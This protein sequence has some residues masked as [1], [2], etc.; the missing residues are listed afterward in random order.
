MLQV[1]ARVGQRTIFSSCHAPLKYPPKALNGFL[2][3]FLSLLTTFAVF[4]VLAA[5]FSS[6]FF[7][8]FGVSSV[9]FMRRTVVF[10]ESEL[11]FC[12]IISPKLKSLFQQTVKPSVHQAAKNSKSLPFSAKIERVMLTLVLIELYM[13]AV[14]ALGFSAIKLRRSVKKYRFRSGAAKAR[15][16][17]L[18]A[19]SVCLPARNETNSMTECLEAVLASDYPKMEVIVLDDNSSD[20]TSHL[21]RAFAHAGV[22]F[23]AGDMP[24]GGWVGRNFALQTLLDEASGK[25][26]LFMDVD[27]R[28]APH[29]ISDIVAYALSHEAKMVS[30]VPQRFDTFRASAKFSTLRYFWEMVL[31][32]PSRPGSSTAV[33][34]VDRSALVNDING[35]TQWR[36]EVQPEMYIARE[37]AKT[38]EY[39]F[40]ISTPALGVHYVKKWSSQVETSRRL[41]LPRFKNSILSV[42][43]GVGLIFS[44]VLPQII[45]LYALVYQQWVIFWASAIFGTLVM[46]LF[47]YYCRIVWRQGWWFGFFIAPYVAWQELVLLISS[48]VGYQAGTITWKGRPISRPQ[49]E[50]SS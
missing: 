43:V 30:I 18:P 29:S 13:I 3:R 34:L 23:V 33:W 42:F 15:P 32:T 22:R 14:G 47:M 19:V 28:L 41:L 39:Q 49:R 20:N 35:F 9:A 17:E 31:D 48:A 10:V 8:F 4:S 12:G 36:D 38:D 37:L 16:E 44:V 50:K 21:I 46:I 7:T 25:Y 45:G 2:D 11:S 5:T 26:V 27:T 24:P 1:A 6:V 40:L